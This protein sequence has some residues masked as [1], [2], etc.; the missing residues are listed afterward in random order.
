MMSREER[1]RVTEK[2]VER[3]DVQCATILKGRNIG[4]REEGSP[5]KGEKHGW[6]IIDL[7]IDSFLLISDFS[8]L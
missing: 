1:R 5:G 6:Y 4:N 2:E 8:S 7:L 3:P